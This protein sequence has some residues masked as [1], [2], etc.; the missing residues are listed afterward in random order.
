MAL[1]AVTPELMLPVEVSVLPLVSRSSWMLEFSTSMYT[2]LR[3]LK[4]IWRRLSS[5]RLPLTWTRARPRS[6]N[7]SSLTLPSMRWK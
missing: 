3:G 7:S 1:A 5:P 6:A 4:P 2:P